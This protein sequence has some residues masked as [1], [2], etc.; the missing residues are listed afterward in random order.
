MGQAEKEAPS[1]V[2]GEVRG[3]PGECVA[4]D[5]KRRDNSQEE[6]KSSVPNYGKMKA[7]EKVLFWF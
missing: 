5:T 2:F 3:K 6:G 4:L 7:Q 1:Q